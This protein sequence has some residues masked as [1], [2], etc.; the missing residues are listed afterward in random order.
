MPSTKENEENY[1]EKWE[2]KSYKEM[3]EKKKRE[4]VENEIGKDREGD[5]E[6]KS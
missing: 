2:Q 3:E 5:N 4:F 6:K 1:C